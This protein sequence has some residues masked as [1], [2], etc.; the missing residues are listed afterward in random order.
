MDAIIAARAAQPLSVM[1]EQNDFSG[2][3]VAP[4]G[5]P[6][7]AN[8]PDAANEATLVSGAMGQTQDLGRNFDEMRERIQEMRQRGELP[9]G[10]GGPGGFGGPGR[11]GGGPGGPGGPVMFGGRGGRFNINR[12]HGSVFYSAGTSVLNAEPYS[13]SGAP[14]EQPDYGSNRFGFAL[15]G[16][17]KIPKVMAPA[18]TFF[19]LSLFG[20]R[21]STPYDVFSHVPTALE[22]QG[23]FS[24]TLDR[25]G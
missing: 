5:V 22:R 7:M 1:Q 3:A 11:F 21:A 9:G 25:N 2:G 23:D 20:T 18:N 6:E 16:P 19:F 24:Q 13:L 8:S 12:V 15:G 17:L 10:P 4:Q 14:T